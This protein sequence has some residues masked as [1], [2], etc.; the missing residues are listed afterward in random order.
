VLDTGT[1]SAVKRS[2]DGGATWQV[3]ANLD[4]AVTEGHRFSYTGDFSVL[5]DILFVRE[6]GRTRFAVGNAGVFA[7]VNGGTWFRLLSTAALPGHPVSAYF[8]NL[9]DPCDRALYV[10][11]DGRGIVRLDP[12]PPP[13]PRTPAGGDRPCTPGTE[14]QP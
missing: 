2:D 12:I 3:D 14:N 9:S 5:K 1:I 8:D 6:E 13:A 7:T 10:G 11:M 4:T